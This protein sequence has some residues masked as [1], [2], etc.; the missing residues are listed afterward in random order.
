MTTKAKSDVKVLKG[1]EAEDKVLEYVKMMNRPYGAVDVSANL[2]GAVPKTA[3]QKIL[4]ALAEKGELVQ[5]TY[6]KTTFFVANQAKI[7]TIPAEQITALETEYKKVDEESKQL[8]AQ[9]KTANVD[10]AKL[11][12]TPSD[13]VLDSQINETRN[14]V[15]KRLA[16]LEPLRSGSQLISA[17]NLAQVDA[18][19]AKWR[20]EWIRRKKIFMSFWQVVTDSLPPSD[21]EKLAEELGIEFDTPEHVSVERGPLC[22]NSG[23]NS[24]KRKR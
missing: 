24:L 20:S 9:L 18:D 2:K 14:L 21:A 13:V 10:L 16:L 4:V 12:A 6:G 3:T 11:K 22:N 7:K 15:E 5:K 1:Q 8:A 17:E 19:W 23:A